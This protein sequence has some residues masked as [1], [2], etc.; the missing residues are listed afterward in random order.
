M[1]VFLDLPFL[2]LDHLLLFLK[3]S[4]LGYN[5]MLIFFHHVLQLCV[6]SQVLT[7]FPRLSLSQN[8]LTSKLLL[9]LLDL[10][11]LLLYLF[12][13]VCV[14]LSEVLCLSPQCLCFFSSSISPTA[15]CL[16]HALCVLR[17]LLQLR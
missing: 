17:S 16:M 4:I 2:G 15:L 14:L 13:F 7:N 6:M 12:L 11:Y 9:E 10:G 1:L 8:S 3:L 5:R